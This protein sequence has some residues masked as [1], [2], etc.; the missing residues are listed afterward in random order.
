MSIPPQAQQAAINGNVIEAVKLTRAHTGW[1]LKEAK[2]AVDAFLQGAEQST[3]SRAEVEIPS[4]AIAALWQ[5]K[6][7]E[8]IQKTRAHTG[9]GLKDS[10]ELVERHLANNPGTQS[11][12][13]AAAA[14]QSRGVARVVRIA[15]LVA[16]VALGYL[17]FTGKLPLS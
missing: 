9:L 1:G 12:F 11:R 16:A 17:W 13:R 10:K 2:D 5:G 15:L 4:D 7:I 6:L 14:E 8:A 3:R